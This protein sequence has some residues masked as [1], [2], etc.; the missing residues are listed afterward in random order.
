M[1]HSIWPRCRPTTWPFMS[2]SPAP[3]C[4]CSKAPVTLRSASSRR[5]STR[6]RSTSSPATRLNGERMPVMTVLG[7]IDGV[8]LGVTLMHEHLLIDVSYKWQPPTEVTLR[9][10]AEQP[11]TLAN[12][13]Y[14]RRNIGAVRANFRLDDVDTAA[15]E[16]LMF[17][18]EGGGTIVD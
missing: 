5:S 16:A 14:L 4:M 8:Q 2:R 6:S 17:K 11:I 3:S 15:A 7:P 9:A 13:G 18:R 10:L 1:A 12:L